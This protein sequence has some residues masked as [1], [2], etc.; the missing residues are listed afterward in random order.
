[1]NKSV[2]RKLA[3]VLAL[4]LLLPFILQGNSVVN[5][6]ESDTNMKAHCTATIDD[7]FD[8][9][10]IIIVIDPSYNFTEYTI[11]DFASIGC[12]S[13]EAL[14]NNITSNSL[15]RIIKLTI[16]SNSKE[17]VLAAI[18]QLEQRSDIYSAEPNYI[19]SVSLAPND[20]GYTDGNQWAIN[21]ISLPSAWNITTGSAAVRVGVID[22]GID[23]SH[24]DLVNRVNANLSRSFS[25]DFV[26]GTNDIH[27][28][29][30]HVAGIIAAQGNNSIGVVGTCWNVELISLRVATPDGSFYVSSA[31]QA[32]DY[33]EE[34]GIPIL[35]YSSGSSSV[36]ELNTSFRVAISNYSGLFVC[37]AGNE[38]TNND[39][40]PHYPS[41]FDLPNV[42][43]VGSSTDTDACAAHSNYGQTSVDLFAPGTSI[44]SCFPTS[45]YCTDDQCN[46]VHYTN[47]YRSLSGT[48]MAAPYVAGIAALILSKHPNISIFH[49][50][51]G[52]MNN[53]DLVNQLS[54]KCV[55]GGR[56]NAYKAVL[57]THYYDSFTKRTSVSHAAICACGNTVLESHTW[58]LMNTGTYICSKCA[59]IPA[60]AEII[61]IFDTE[62]E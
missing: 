30:T 33:A 48:S 8:D 18:E 60:N 24:P 28:H 52:I 38:S 25:R 27:G 16:Q 34:I 17:S 29:G 7:E 54:E 50:K 23:N 4:A 9:S 39:I 41:N 45:Y 26:L 2:H 43:A 12:T 47:G 40:T 62:T 6:V 59:Y 42:I 53:C 56:L 5:A 49:I 55:S 13:I 15:C 35:N 3:F 32:I 21:K 31:I 51:S 19:E 22:T 58:V 57:N 1:M 46:D 61:S 44:L 37:A 14:T 20:P 11:N 36:L 10:E